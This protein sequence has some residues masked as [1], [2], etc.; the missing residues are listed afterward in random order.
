MEI[1]TRLPTRLDTVSP[2]PEPFHTFVPPVR[3]SDFHV[4][5][6]LALELGA[7]HGGR[8]TGDYLSVQRRSGC[9]EGDGAAIAF[10][11]C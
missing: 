9:S 11:V 7:G 6:V 5:D 3:I 1:D 10:L 2:A 8:K 4:S